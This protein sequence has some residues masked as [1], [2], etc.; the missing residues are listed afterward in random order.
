VIYAVDAADALAVT[1]EMEM[2]RDARGAAFDFLKEIGR[3]MDDCGR[4]TPLSLFLR[5]RIIDQRWI[6]A[7]L[8]ELDAGLKN[9][10][11]PSR[12]LAAAAQHRA[13]IRK[14]NGRSCLRQ[15]RRNHAR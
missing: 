3:P 10:T 11:V 2:F 14:P 5:T 7:H 8:N 6:V 1:R 12:A 13:L 4:E 9:L 15:A